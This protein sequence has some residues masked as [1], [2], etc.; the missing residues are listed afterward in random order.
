MADFA[1]VGSLGSANEYDFGK[2]TLELSPS[3]DVDAGDLVVVWATW[4]SH[5]FF[6]PNG[7]QIAELSCTDDAGNL[8]LQ[9]ASSYVNEAYVALFVS[10]LRNDLLTTN[11]ITL[12]H[13]GPGAKAASLEQFTLT[14]GKRWGFDLEKSV[15]T[16]IAVADPQSLTISGLE[17]AREYLLLHCLGAQGPN[18][19][20][21]TW[22]SDYTQIAGDGTSTGAPSGGGPP[23]LED[24]HVRGGFR[25]VTGITSDTVDVTSTGTDRDNDQ[26]L[27]ALTPLEVDED[28]PDF[29]N[30]PILDDFNRANEDP[31]DA[32][33]WQ[34]TG[35]QPGFGTAKNRVVSNRAA[36]SST[37]TGSGSQYLLEQFDTD[38]DAG[39]Y[40]NYGTLAVA[41][42][43]VLY[44]G[45]G[46]GQS[47]TVGATGVA[48]RDT[49]QRAFNAASVAMGL[50]YIGDDGFTGEAPG[51]LGGLVWGPAADGT[52]IGI[53]Q[54]TIDTWTQHLWIDDGGGWEW[55][56][57]VLRSTLSAFINEGQFG[58]GME[59]NTATRLDDLGGGL[60]FRFIPGII[61][62]P[63]D[64]GG[65]RKPTDAS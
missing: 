11:T 58:I 24:V 65:S 27:V 1:S 36:M 16:G 47:V 56:C 59:G 51:G 43:L 2:N 45:G 32:G 57:G 52:K 22:D 46:S 4:T 42:D 25:I 14:P 54:L 3:S 9:L 39:E 17:S 12:K 6:G 10:Q 41:H 44:F 63:P 50:V 20:A 5:Y 19:D 64:P 38:E 40:E 60:L 62:R 15:F 8:Y 7:E 31:L 33:I 23:S 53:Q 13:F 35:D 18:T 55:V 21:Y 28:F 48:Y 30:T 37:G 29:P 61:R 49:G 26:C 34:T